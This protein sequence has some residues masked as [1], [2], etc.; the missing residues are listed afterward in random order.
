MSLEER[1]K[2]VRSGD[3]VI[4]R[5]FRYGYKEGYRAACKEITQ[6][7]LDN[8]FVPMTAGDNDVHFK[9]GYI[10]D[11]WDATGIGNPFVEKED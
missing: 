3:S 10:H 6:W 2:Q 7:L 1:T 4:D 11:M 9:S 5:H 8:G